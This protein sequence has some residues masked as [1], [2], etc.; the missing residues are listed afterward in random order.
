M[1][2]TTHHRLIRKSAIKFSVQDRQQHSQLALILLTPP[3]TLMESQ[4][5]SSVS[6]STSSTCF[7]TSQRA[8]SG[9]CFWGWGWPKMRRWLPSPM[10]SSQSSSSQKLQWRERLGWFRNFWS[11]QISMAKVANVVI[12]AKVGIVQRGIREVTRMIGKK[13]DQWKC[14]HGQHGGHITENFLSKQCG[15]PPKAAHTAA[16][17]STETLA[18]LTLT[19]SIENYWMAASSHTLCCDRF[20]HCRCMTYTSGHWSMIMGY[21]RYHLDTIEVKGYN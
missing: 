2:P 4:I 10:K 12:M 15:D 21:T 11:L 18:T 5:P 13:K 7:A 6:R 1:S 8:M 16:E 20:I 3:L 9:K 14:F 17:A 19:T